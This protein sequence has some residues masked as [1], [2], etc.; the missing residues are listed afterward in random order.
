MALA[1][2]ANGGNSERAEETAYPSWV[3]PASEGIPH[4]NGASFLESAEAAQARKDV[5][6]VLGNDLHMK[7]A[8]QQTILAAKGE[9]KVM[10]RGETGTGKEVICKAIHRLRGKEKPFVD[11]NCATLESSLAASTLF[12]HVKG[13]FT[14]A[15]NTHKGIFEQGNGGTVF[16]DEV[17]EM[18][19]ALQSMLLRVL[20][21]DE[22]RP[23]GS[24]KTVKLENVKVIAA[25]NKPLEKFIK[26]GRFQEDLYYRL[27]THQ[28]V[29]PALRNR[30]REHRMELIGH[31]L[32]GRKPDAL[33]SE[34]ALETLLS[35]PMHGNVREL[36]HILERA[37]DVLHEG[38]VLIMPH[39]LP[40]K[41]MHKHPLRED[42]PLRHTLQ[43]S[44][45]DDG[46]TLDASIRTDHVHGNVQDIADAVRMKLIVMSLER[47]GG[48]INA[49]AAETGIS[50][51]T[52]YRLLGHKDPMASGH[53]RVTHS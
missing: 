35:L 40:V 13:S 34:E 18:S 10:L 41:A 3:R 24:E 36:L 7:E 8:W 47:H 51:A 16:L 53:E 38:E 4:H 31:V 23:L 48:N 1:L 28:I 50:R 6:L 39:H 37:V 32:H 42:D 11:I 27:S 5:G 15:Q 9:G 21:T 49:V 17:S 2:H 26:E 14:G 19:P 30:T 12:G 29:L 44:L 20:E 22:V 46:E 45:S 33:M 52:L 25:S 43:F